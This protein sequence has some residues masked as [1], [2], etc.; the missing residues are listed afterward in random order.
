MGK[1]LSFDNEIKRIIKWTEQECGQDIPYDF[2][3]EI[4]ERN[5]NDYA[6]FDEIV[7][8]MENDAAIF[9][10][11]VNEQKGENND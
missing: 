8:E 11:F 6:F 3:W 7:E 10:D 1:V 5:D 4:V 2:L 9:I